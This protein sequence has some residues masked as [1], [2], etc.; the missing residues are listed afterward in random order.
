MKPVVLVNTSCHRKSYFTFFSSPSHS[1]P[2][3]KN[4]KCYG[5]NAD[6]IH[7]SQHHLTANEA[8]LWCNKLKNS[9]LQIF[10]EIHV[11]LS[12]NSFSPIILYTDP[13]K[14]KYIL[15]IV[16][17]WINYKVHRFTQR[18]QYSNSNVTVH[19]G[20]CETDFSTRNL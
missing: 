4:V 20:H 5:G 18:I 16:Q 11:A 14:L 13:V 6:C 17:Y 8:V 12:S 3:T 7:W 9:C 1:F 10:L 15:Y 19:S 2:S